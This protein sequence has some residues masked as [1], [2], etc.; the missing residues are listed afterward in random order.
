MKKVKLRE[1]KGGDIFIRNKRAFQFSY[2]TDWGTIVVL[3]LK[4][5]HS[6][7]LT[8]EVIVLTNET[9]SYEHF[10]RKKSY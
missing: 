2:K 9:L 1:L 7:S 5:R 4:Y 3:E 10:R 6:Y 8:D